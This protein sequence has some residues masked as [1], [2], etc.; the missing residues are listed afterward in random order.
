MPIYIHSSL[1]V[2]RECGE[3]SPMLP[4]IAIFMHINKT[5]TFQIIVITQKTNNNNNNLKNVAQ[6]VQRNK[7]S[8][9]NIKNIYY[10][11]LNGPRHCNAIKRIKTR[12][13][14][15]KK[16]KML[17]AW[18]L[19]KY[20]CPAAIVLR[21]RSSKKAKSKQRTGHWANRKTSGN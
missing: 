17:L 2:F 7:Y 10:L 9:A 4:Y 1:Y 11:Q 13:E 18:K 12:V 20:L 6:N 21:T 15:R 16:Y 14:A 8:G 3:A 19:L 5:R